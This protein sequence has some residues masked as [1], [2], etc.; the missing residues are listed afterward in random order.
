MI[1]AILIALAGIHGG[2]VAGHVVNGNEKAEPLPGATVC[3]KASTVCAA[4]DGSGYFEIGNLPFTG[5]IM[6]TAE[7]SGFHGGEAVACV[8][9][10]TPNEAVVVMDTASSI[11]CTVWT[12]PPPVNK[13]T[14][15]V[16]DM[17]SHPVRH[18]AL[19]IHDINGKVVWHSYSDRRGRFD[20]SGL[21]DGRYV[22]EVTKRGYLRQTVTLSFQYCRPHVDLTIPLANACRD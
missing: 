4:T 10:G 17:T 16:T 14:G 13:V 8:S 15:V 20:A 3:V 2:S 21:R 6:L 19:K 22:V 5:S 7:L 11:S 1:V 12:G 18:T 9:N